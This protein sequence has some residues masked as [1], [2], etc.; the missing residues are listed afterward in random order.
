M[1][2]EVLVSA[3]LLVTLSLGTAHLFGFAIAQNQAARQQLVMGT[4]ASAKID[5]LSAAI[6][7]GT[8]VAPAEDTITAAGRVYV[9]RWQVADVPGYGVDAEVVTVRVAAAVGS[10]PEYRLTTIRAAGA[11]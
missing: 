10:G 11:P 8:V 7:I 1:L 3:G 5:E 4:L 2:I 6:A 9:R